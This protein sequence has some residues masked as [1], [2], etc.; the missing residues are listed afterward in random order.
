MQAITFDV[1]SSRR[2]S[3]KRFTSRGSSVCVTVLLLSGLAAALAADSGYH[4]LKT[5]AF[6][7]APGSTGEYFDYV[8]VDAAA[9]RVYLSR[10]TAV[11]VIDADTGAN[12][13]FVPG[14]M[15]QHG[16]ALAP[17]FNRGFISDGGQAKIFVFDLKTLKIVGEVKADP[18]TDCMVYDPASKNA[19]SMNGDGNSTTVVNAKTGELVKTIPLGGAP[20]FAVTDGK[21]M[22]YADLANK[23][24]IVGVDTR[25][26]EVKSR[27]P[28]APA[29]NPTSLAMDREHRRLFSAGRNPQMLVIVNA[30]NGKV[31]QSFPI[32]AGT[33]AAAYDPA[34]GM[35]YIST[36]DGDIHV[37]HEDSPDKYSVVDDVKTQYGAKTMGL[38]TKTHELFLDTADFGAPAAPAANGRPGRRTPVAGTFRV[39]V[40]GR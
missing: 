35:I 26:L 1:E 6:G 37:F 15:R 10:G 40:Y 20:E 2:L 22:L 21:G 34:S 38:D 8:T 36:I 11:Q 27:W 32:S 30:D 4:L 29:G 16:V 14:F 24:E 7:A 28:V 19:F 18:D 31:V 17:E 39:L 25:T 12:V 5:Y 33:D 9:R 23:N 3:M 13:G